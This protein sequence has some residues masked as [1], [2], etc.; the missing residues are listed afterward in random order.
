MSV[1]LFLVDGMRP[2]GLQQAQTPVMDQLIATGAHTFTA[3]TVMPSITLPVHTSLFLG[4]TPERHGNT[5]NIWTPPARPVP[6]LIDVLHQADKTTASFY[7]WEPLRDLSRPGSLDA[8]FFVR[9]HFAPEG[10]TRVARIAAD[11]LAHHRVDFAFVYFGYTDQAGHDH[12]WMSAPYRAAIENAD[13][14]IGIVR[15]AL[16]DAITIVMSDHGGH[17]QTH[18]SDSA[19]DMIIPFIING[20]NIPRGQCIERAVHITDIAP[21]IARLFQVQ[22]PV[23]W[24]GSSIVE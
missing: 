5:T 3:R 12:G 4:V 23:E 24:I 8:A 10:D 18:G 22:S 7:N 17:A 15:E 11:W 9:D 13:R 1:I 2:D 16:P 14:C 19:D 21:T 6:G 20:A